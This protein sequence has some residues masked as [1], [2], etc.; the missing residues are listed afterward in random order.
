MEARPRLRSNVQGF[1]EVLLIKILIIKPRRSLKME[2]EKPRLWSSAVSLE[3]VKSSV[4]FENFEGTIL[5]V[6]VPAVGPDEHY[7]VLEKLGLDLEKLLLDKNRVKG[8]IKVEVEHDFEDK[9]EGDSWAR[10]IDG[11]RSVWRNQEKQ[12]SEVEVAVE[13]IKNNTSNIILFSFVH[14]S[15]H[16]SD[17]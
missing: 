5:V 8:G 11:V 7:R 13:G 1:S 14:R 9:V 17:I 15:E 16:T 10:A 12:S 4:A 6:L 3:R 2:K